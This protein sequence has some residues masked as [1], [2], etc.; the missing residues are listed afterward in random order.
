MRALCCVGCCEKTEI[1]LQ[2]QLM[3]LTRG[4]RDCEQNDRMQLNAYN[5][6]WEAGASHS[7][8]TEM[9]L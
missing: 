2:T 5:S 4:K 7:S 6:P 8:C 1:W 9:G 3:C